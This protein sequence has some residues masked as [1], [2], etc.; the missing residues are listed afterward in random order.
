[1]TTATKTSAGPPVIVTRGRSGAP[2]HTTSACRLATA[3][4]RPALDTD[5]AECTCVSI[6]DPGV[7]DI[8]CHTPRNRSADPPQTPSGRA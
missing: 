8:T 4:Y 7:L 6:T 2:D 3:R 5:A 1:M